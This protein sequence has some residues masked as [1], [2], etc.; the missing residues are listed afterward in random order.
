MVKSTVN[1]WDTIQKELNNLGVDLDQLCGDKLDPKKIKVVCLGSGMR[2]SLSE[3]GDA[4]RDKVVMVRV[5]E[6]TSEELDAWVETEVVKSR[7]E[8]AALF[9]REGLKVRADELAQLKDA[10]RDVE[11]AKE[12][13]RHKARDVFDGAENA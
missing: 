5:D 3:L 11:R 4:I 2:E 6:E 8:A 1:L 7:S 9:I 10:L 13:L 12:N